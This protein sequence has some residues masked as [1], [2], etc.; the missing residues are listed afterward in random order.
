M[1]FKG[2]RSGIGLLGCLSAGPETGAT[3]SEG[4][5][6]A[7]GTPRSRVLTP[8]MAAA[9]RLKRDGDRL[10]FS[11][12]VLQRWRT[13]LAFGADFET[14]NGSKGVQQGAKKAT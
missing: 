11:V 14:Q 3:A 9:L 7:S 5:G 6:A 13:C 12:L 1:S 4:A 2:L 8:I 10:S